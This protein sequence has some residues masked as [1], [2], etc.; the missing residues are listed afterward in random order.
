M[1][2][3]LNT[4]NWPAIICFMLCLLPGLANAS[5]ITYQMDLDGI[6]EV[7]VGDLDGSAAGTISFDDVTGL[8]SWDLSYANIDTPTA[9]H[10]HG[11]GGTAGINAGVFIGLG[12][13]TSGG[14]NTL[15][16]SLV[17]NLADVNMII[18]D[19]GGFY[20]NIHTAEFP[21]GSVRGQLGNVLVPAPGTLPLLI[22]A[23]LFLLQ[24]SLKTRLRLMP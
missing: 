18:N 11:P 20:I 17:A 10:I 21:P 4:G 3:I 16:D 9:M 13:N 6:Q 22:I 15:I 23:A 5:L 19:P 12:V 24:S 8:I 14:A 1:R 7:P 2:K